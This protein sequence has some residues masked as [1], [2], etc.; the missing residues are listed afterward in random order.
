MAAMKNFL[1]Y[2]YFYDLLNAK[3]SRVSYSLI[4]FESAIF[5]IIDQSIPLYRCITCRMPTQS[6]TV[7]LRLGVSDNSVQAGL[8]HQMTGKGSAG[9][10]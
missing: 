1:I 2:F 8:L 10:L 7:R 5:P 9:H 3:L 6:Q 4:T